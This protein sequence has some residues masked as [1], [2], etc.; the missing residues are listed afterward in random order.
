MEGDR[1]RSMQT[2][3]LDLPFYL[4]G[5]DGNRENGHLSRFVL[6]AGNYDRPARMEDKR[7]SRSKDLRERW[8]RRGQGG[9]G[10]PLQAR[11]PGCSDNAGG[12]PVPVPG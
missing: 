9:S 7:V 6:S 1:C 11:L 10:A 3:A 8:P 2:A 12:G 5:K 4:K